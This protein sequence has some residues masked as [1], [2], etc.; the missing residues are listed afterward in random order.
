ML[1]RVHT[2]TSNRF[3]KVAFIDEP[4][5]HDQTCRD[6]VF[7]PA[8]KDLENVSHRLR[9]VRDVRT[10]LEMRLQTWRIIDSQW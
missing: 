1:D 2:P 9:S 8:L 5:L 4:R 6:I 7:Q 10:E 3:G